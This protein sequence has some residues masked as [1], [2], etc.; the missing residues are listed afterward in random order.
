MRL[1]SNR[2]LAAM[3]LIASPFSIS[4]NQASEVVD[5]ADISKT[6]PGNHLRQ[7]GA[8]TQA[9]ALNDFIYQAKGF[10]N[11]FMVVTGQGNVI[12]DTSLKAMAPL[13][14]KL[15]SAVSDAPI[16]AI[17]L[18]HAHGDH[19]GGVEL[20]RQVDTKVIAQQNM[21]ELLHYRKRLEG[22]FKLRNSAQF[23]YGQVP[24]FEPAQHAGNFGANIVPNTLF[25]KEYQFSLGGVDF[26]IIHTPAETYDA[27]T[28]WLPQSKT[29]FVGDMFYS[30]FP[31]MYTLRGTK[32]RWALDYVASLNRV[33]ALEPELL[34]PSHGEAV[35]GKSAI[36]AAL[37]RY[38]DAI[39]YVHDQTVLGMNQGKDVF[40]LMRDIKLPAALDIGENYGWVS[41]SV[42]GIYEGYMG[43]FDG[44]PVNMYASA[45]ESIYGDLVTLAGGADKVIALAQ[46]SLNQGQNVKALRL[47]EAALAAEP[48]NIAALNQRLKVLSLLRQ[49]SGNFNESGW[50]DFAIANTKR[51]LAALGE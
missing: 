6:D 17:I 22:M 43:W 26:E 33:L 20:W 38:R 31:N 48:N 46:S 24:A 19:I 25:D 1:F 23:G 11:T 4:L 49:Q 29:V 3:L 5:T 40:T 37:T 27:L 7:G 18:T 9:I 39:L 14:K 47:M 45:P 36:Q 34:L 12:V 32:P 21:V 35:K 30:S 8:K 2:L 10:G 41:W 51:D 15:L 50:L 44:K 42:R 13:H 28:V 16:E